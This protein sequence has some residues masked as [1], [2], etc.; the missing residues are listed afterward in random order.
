MPAMPMLKGLFM[1]LFMPVAHF[2]GQ[3]CVVPVP[4]PVFPPSFFELPLK[5]IAEDA[6]C[7]FSGDCIC[8]LQAGSSAEYASASSVG[9][10]S[11][12]AG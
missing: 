11:G 7:T 4:V 10:W 2:A 5:T 9:G 1:G 8:T 3:L 6:A 12:D